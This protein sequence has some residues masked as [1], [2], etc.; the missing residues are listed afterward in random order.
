MA[1]FFFFLQGKQKIWAYWYCFFIVKVGS[2]F[3]LKKKK[4][5]KAKKHV[6]CVITMCHLEKLRAKLKCSPKVH[7]FKA[8]KPGLWRGKAAFPPPA[9]H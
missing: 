4:D 6:V 2:Y 5:C 3:S 8:G 1:F 9:P 7:T